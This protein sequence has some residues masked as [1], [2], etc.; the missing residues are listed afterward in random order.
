M[1]KILKKFY[2]KVFPPKPFSNV[3]RAMLRYNWR[4]KI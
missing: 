3:E 4:K 2:K 1:V